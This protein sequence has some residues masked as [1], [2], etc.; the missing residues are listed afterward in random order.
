MN[1]VAR[2]VLFCSCLWGATR[3]GWVAAQP[4][5]QDLNET[6][7]TLPVTVKNLY[8]RSVTGNVT[9][10]Q[11][12]PT[13]AGPFPIVI[14]NHGRN[15]ENR[16][17][18][19]RFRYTQQARLF[20]DRGFVVFVPTRIGYG[21]AGVDP[22]PENSGSCNQ[23]SYGPMAE[24]AVTEVLAVV[25]YAKQQPY[26][27]P[28]R[29]LLVGQSAGG[30]TTTAAA[31]RNPPGLAAEINFAGGAGGDPLAHPGVPCQGDKLESMYAQFGNTT[32]VPIL[33]VYTENDLYFW[34]K[35]SQAWRAAFNKSGGQAEYKLLP[36]FAKNGHLLFA[37]GL[38]IWEP[39][40]ADFLGRN[41]FPS[42]LLRQ[43]QAYFESL[44]RYHM[45]ANAKLLEQIAVLGEEDYR[46]DCG[47]FF[48]SIHGTLNHMLVAE[49]H[50][51]SRIAEGISLKMA[52]DSE[53]ESRRDLLARAL[54]DAAQCWGEWL[55]S[56]PQRDYS[57]NRHYTRAAGSPDAAPITA[58]LG[59]VFNHATHHRG[60]ITAALTAMGHACPELDFIYWAVATQQAEM[61]K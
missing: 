36:P 25:A 60:Q 52:L 38:S 26:V 14:I 2:Y 31:V 42:E 33:W 13:G 3:L 28:E 44:A 21:E 10:T 46:R 15:G 47:L 17:M 1:Y 5:A 29:V 4:I 40:V 53:L 9:V 22:D 6:V 32:K 23:K 51:Q 54:A 39:I 34:P 55:S 24:A 18:P 8:R 59:H 7:I 35:Y 27:N 19:P 61:S 41:G 48:H 30:Y 58:V 37:S 49:C 43:W 57:G 16:A 11:F 45:W 12:K 20:I 56:N 50:W